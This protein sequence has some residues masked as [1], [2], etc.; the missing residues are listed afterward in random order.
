MDVPSMS[1]FI[2]SLPVVAGSMPVGV[3]NLP[4]APGPESTLPVLADRL[5]MSADALQSALR[6]GQSIAGLA[7]RQAVTRESVAEVVATQ[8]QQARSIS[9][10]PPL[11]PGALERTVDRALDRGQAKDTSAS[12]EAAP[13]TAGGVGAYANNARVTSGG[14]PAGRMISLLA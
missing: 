8:I 10:Q 5:G 2:P 9:G 1:A 14:V 11:D 7:E 6:D 13:P 4:P 12:G 3:L